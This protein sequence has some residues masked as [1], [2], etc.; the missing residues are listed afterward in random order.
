MIRLVFQRLGLRSEL[1]GDD[2]VVPG[3][4]KLVVQR[5]AG[6][7][8]SKVEDGPVARVPGRPHVDRAGARDAVRGH[9]ADLRE[10]VREPPRLHRQ[11]GQHGRA[12]HPLRP[13][14]GVISGPRGCAASALESPDIRAGMAMLIA[15]LCADGTRRSATSAR[16]TA[17][18]SASTSGC[19][20]WARGSSARS[21]SFCCGHDDDP[22]DAVRDA[23]R[24]ARRDARDARCRRVH[25]RRVRR[26]R[27]RRGAHA[28]AR[29]RA[30]ADARRPGG[31][32]SGLQAVRRA[33]QRA[34]A[35]LGHDDPDRAR[36]LGPLCERGSAAALLLRR[37]HLPLRAA[38]SAGRTARCCRPGSSSSGC[39][40][41]PAPPRR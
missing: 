10:D 34:G 32:R 41:P 36:R 7:Y 1:D 27:L 23:R 33:G 22:P 24:P 14:P 13:A 18:T 15:A 5:D 3:E 4:Q 29:V 30:G 8:Q 17:A 28:G 35:A 31:G 26:T 20:R 25:A 11:A 9:G 16:S 37:P 40:V 2:V 21:R 39:P 38:R 12:H 6:G 19:A